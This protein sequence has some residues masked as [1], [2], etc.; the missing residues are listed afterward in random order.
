[1]AKQN[2]LVTERPEGSC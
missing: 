2:R 1:M